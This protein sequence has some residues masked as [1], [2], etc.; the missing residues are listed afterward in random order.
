M[1]PEDAGLMPVS[2]TYLIAGCGI[3]CGACYAHLRPKNK[4]PGCNAPGSDKMP[5]CDHCKIKNCDF[6]KG[7]PG[8][9]CSGCP[10]F[11]CQRLKQINKRYSA[12]YHEELILNLRKIQTEGI[13][14]FFEE[15]I[16]KR[17]CS[18]CGHV[19]NL[20]TRVC[21]GCGLQTVM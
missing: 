6:L 16:Q 1:K 12:R 3:N 14:H 18:Q 5:H 4:C 15:D 21:S 20:H 2:G 19:I 13:D 10:K 9:F 8:S 11:P 7:N 17:T